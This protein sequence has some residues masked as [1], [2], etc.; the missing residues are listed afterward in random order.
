MKQLVEPEKIFFF[1]KR[2]RWL[3]LLLVVL[4]IIIPRDVFA[5]WHGV[6]CRAMILTDATKY[7][8]LYSKNVNLRVVPASTVKIMTALLVLE[9]LPLEGYVTVSAKATGVPPSKL[10]LRAGERYKV[11]DLLYGMLLKS[12][13]DAAIVLA[14]AVAG[15]EWQFVQMMNNRAK[16]LGANNTKFANASGLPAHRVSQYT[17]AY[18][19]YLM[20]AKALQYPFFR[21][22][23]KRRY[24]IFYSQEGRR[25]TFKNHNKIL[26][27]GWK[28]KV[29]GKTGYT[30]SAGPCFVGTI[31]KG[32]SDLIVAAFNCHDRWDD[33]KYVV[34]A[35]GGV[36]L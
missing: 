28:N 15:S 2:Q 5:R 33:I 30:R 16:Q 1:F 18:D 9:K 11:K 17:T 35:F 31:K 20:F 19:M 36:N 13:N 12:G 4:T 26:F 27:M 21:E 23:I 14:E 8:R 25:I 29:Y 24:G 10:F 3:L 32:N 34:S 7:R 22:I 6:S